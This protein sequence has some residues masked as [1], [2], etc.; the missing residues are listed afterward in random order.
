[1]L[2]EVTWD[3]HAFASRWDTNN[4]KWPFV[5]ATGSVHPFPHHVST[6][7]CL[8]QPLLP[9]S[10]PT[11]YSWHGDFQNGW[12]LTALQNAID[13]C[14]N[15][16]DATG[17]G[18]TEACQY[19]NVRQASIANQCKIKP[20]TNEVITGNLTKL[21]GCNPLQAGPANATMY[22]EANCPNA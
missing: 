5:Y 3:V 22:T 14:D 18:K 19:L 9:N 17:D 20:I 1:M 15:P 16:N 2:Y 4:G 7:M 6:Y 13:K 21:P 8:I 10:D 12:D 11:G